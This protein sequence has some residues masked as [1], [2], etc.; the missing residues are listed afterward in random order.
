MN[1]PKLIQERWK[2]IGCGACMSVAPDF[3]EMGDDA[4]S[5]MKIAHTS[6]KTRDGELH[7]G[8]LK[9]EEVESNKEAANVCPVNCIK[10]Q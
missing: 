6:K 7:E 1:M 10:V 8:E 3:W 9:K 4:K 2:C 5:T